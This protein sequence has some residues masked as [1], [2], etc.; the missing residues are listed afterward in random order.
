MQIPIL[1]GIYADSTGEYRTS[2]P[3]NLAPIPKKQGISNGYLKPAEGIVEFATGPG[4]DRGGFNWNGTLYRVMGPKFCSVG[5]TG[6]VAILGDVTNDGQPVKFDNSFD[7]LAI[8][9]GNN[10]YYW[11][12]VTLSQLTDLDLGNV[13]S[14]IWVDGY[15]MTTDG[16]N[17]VVTELNDPYAVNPLKYGSAEVS[18][19]PIKCMLKIADEPCAVGRYTIELFDN[20]GG[21]LFPFQRVR[22]ALIERGT[23]GRYTACVFP[24]Q[25]VFGIAFLGG[26]QKEPCSIW[27]G[28]NATSTRLATREIDT[29]L[30]TYT[31]DQLAAA[32]VECRVD[33]VQSLLYVHLPDQTLVYDAKASEVVQEP[34]WYTLASSI[35]GNSAYRAR[36]LVWAYGKWI[37]G[38][39]N[40]TTYKLGYYV[41]NISSH[42]GDIIGW[43]FGTLIVYNEGNNAIF[44]EIE[45]IGLPGRNVSTDNPVI[46]TSY[47]TDGETWS[48]E[49]TCNGGKKGQRNK[50]L[51]W[52]QMGTMMNSNIRIQKFRGTSNFHASLASIEA[53]L[54][55]LSN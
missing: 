47:S 16:E 36:N 45:L 54:E 4:I 29:L 27:F 26:A 15:F 7:L 52:L 38:D 22:G 49:R 10:F 39:T 43:E 1:N 5:P 40:D 42:Y 6:A 17:I 53:R 3:R 33:K 50:R 31:E 35:V 25:G 18:A 2:Y 8:N 51:L 55:P 21:A 9:S 11:N 41:D 34:V 37:S 12:G 20:I 32:V 48:Q 44:H 14:F 19:D 23:I 28:V 30:Q 24:V 13:V 46:Y